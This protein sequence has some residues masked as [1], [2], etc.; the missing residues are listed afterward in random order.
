MKSAVRNPDTENN[1][2]EF[3]MPQ[4]SHHVFFLFHSSMTSPPEIHARIR[5]TNGSFVLHLDN[6]NPCTLFYPGL[7]CH[8]GFVMIQIA[9]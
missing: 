8:I 5:W 6:R 2:L 3:W 7:V 1:A 9:K 4:N